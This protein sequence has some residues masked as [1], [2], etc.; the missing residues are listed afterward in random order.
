MARAFNDLDCYSCSFG[1]KNGKSRD[2]YDA[3]LTTQLRDDELFKMKLH[4]KKPEPLTVHEGYLNLNHPAKVIYNPPATIIIWPMGDK[5]VVKCCEDDIYDPMTGFLLCCLK[6]YIGADNDPA[7]FHRFL[8]DF[9]PKPEQYDSED[10]DLQQAY[11]KLNIAASKAALSLGDAAVRI[12]D[13]ITKAFGG[14][15]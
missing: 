14:D 9:G 4:N 5:T 1:R 15:K 10:T 6:H 3:W 11:A 8:K 2:L 12:L 13:G 7:K